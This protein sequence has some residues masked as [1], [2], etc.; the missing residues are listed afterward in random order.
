MVRVLALGVLGLGC[1]L[2]WETQSASRPSRSQRST[3]AGRSESTTN[4][5][6]S[7]S[8][9]TN[10]S[11]ALAAYRIIG[12]RNIFNPNR[13][14]RTSAATVDAPPPKIVKVD[15]ASLVGT[16]IH[17]SGMIAFFDGSSDLFRKAV[18][19][20]DTFGGCKVIAV[21]PD[22]VWLEMDGKE[23]E[24]KVGMQIRRQ[25]QGE[26]QLIGKP[27]MASQSGSSGDGS[28]K[29][30]GED[31]SAIADED[32]VVKKMIARREKENSK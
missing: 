3:A 13:G 15:T 18:K 12:E 16:L 20:S 24:V 30:S 14:P 2:S 32:D 25:D 11:S 23:V 17:G 5:S 31:S 29:S 28:G 27:V 21:A 9:S 6:S 7:T 4:T 10:N 26:W 19:P 1:L 8:S 22:S